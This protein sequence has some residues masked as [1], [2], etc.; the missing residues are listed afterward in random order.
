MKIALLILLAAVLVGCVKVK[1]SEPVTDAE[2]G[3]RCQVKKLHGHGI[4][5]EIGVYSVMVDGS[6]YIVIRSINSGGG[7]SILPPR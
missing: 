3:K 1:P 2:P 7:L 6:E 4:F 5:D